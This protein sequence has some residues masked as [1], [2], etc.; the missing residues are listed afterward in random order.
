MIED[1][2]RHLDSVE[3]ANRFNRCAL[4]ACRRHQQCDYC[5]GA[6]MLVELIVLLAE[7]SA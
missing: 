1:W 6:M 7:A 5:C 2:H 3:I 4:E